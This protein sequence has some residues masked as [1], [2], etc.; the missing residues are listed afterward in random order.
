MVEWWTSMQ[1]V[2]GVDLEY[3]RNSNKIVGTNPVT[4]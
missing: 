1:K 4:I 2:L 3:H